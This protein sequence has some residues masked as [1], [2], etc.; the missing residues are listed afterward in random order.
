[1]NNITS[2]YNF[3]AGNYLKTYNEPVKLTSTGFE[4]IDNAMDGGYC[5]NS[6]VTIGANPSIE[7]DLFL[8]VFIKKQLTDKRRLMFFSIDKNNS[9]YDLPENNYLFVSDKPS[10]DYISSAIRAAKPD[11]V[12]IDNFQRIKSDSTTKDERYR[13]TDIVLQLKAAARKANCCIVFLSDF[14]RD[15]QTAPRMSDLKDCGVLEEI[16]NYIFLLYR[17]CLSDGSN[18]EPE[19]VIA[20]LDKNHFGKTGIFDLHFDDLSA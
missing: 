2:N 17:P 16:S 18:V 7:K 20:V 13:L 5:P 8:T 11:V 4:Q 10:V 1:M 15:Y 14:Y 3:N 19:K 12:L 6:L 9:A